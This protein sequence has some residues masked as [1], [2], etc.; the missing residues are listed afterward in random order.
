MRKVFVFPVLG[1]LVFSTSNFVVEARNETTIAKCAIMNFEK[2]YERSKAVFV[3]KVVKIEK[4][5]NTKIFTFKVKKFWKGVDRKTVKVSVGERARFQSPYK[6]DGKYLV[7]AKES[8]EGKLR[9]FRCSRSR[10]LNGFGDMAK[11]DLKKLG[12]GKTCIDLDQK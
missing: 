10:D 5:G 8:E 3:G 6:V 9:D 2:E 12:K 11:E 7:F 1:G 4:D